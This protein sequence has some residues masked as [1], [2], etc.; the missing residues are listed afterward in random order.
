MDA[1]F[2]ATSVE[3]LRTLQHVT[4]TWWKFQQ[5][6]KCKKYMLATCQIFFQINNVSFSSRMVHNKEAIFRINWKLCIAL[7]IFISLE[8]ISGY[9]MFWLASPHFLA[10]WVMQCSA[11]YNLSCFKWIM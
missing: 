5:I 2:L 10:F 7:H 3:Q 4:N 8:L 11:L 9:V 1:F 6:I